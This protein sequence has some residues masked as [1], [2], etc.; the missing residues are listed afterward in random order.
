MK[1]SVDDAFDD[2]PV[3]AERPRV[4]WSVVI[5]D[6]CEDCE[7]LRVE[8]TLEE[9][10]KRGTGLAAHLDPATAKR[11]RAAL[12]TALRQLGEPDES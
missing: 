4:S 2:H 1:Q 5:A 3:D 6:D 12:A 7:D 10:G 8:L 11:L 9:D